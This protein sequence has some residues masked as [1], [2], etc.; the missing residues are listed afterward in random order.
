MAND[1]LGLPIDATA[2][3]LLERQ[4]LRIEGDLHPLMANLLYFDDVLAALREPRA[5]AR[6]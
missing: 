4:G 5:E 1:P 2:E 6:P 3:D